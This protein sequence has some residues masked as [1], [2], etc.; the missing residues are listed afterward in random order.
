MASLGAETDGLPAVD[1]SQPAS[2]FPYIYRPYLPRQVPHPDLANSDSAPLPIQNGKLQLSVSR[3]IA[4]V[5]D[6]N[7]TIAAFRQYLSIAQTE[8]LRSRSGASPRGVDAA[9]IPSEVFAGAQGGS[10]LAGGNG[11]GGGGGASN[12]GGITGAATQVVIRPA[13][14]FDPT[15]GLNFS[16]DHTNNPLNTLV[17]AGVPSVSTGTNAFSIN[18]SQAFPTGTSF[19][20][21]YGMQRQGSTQLHLLYV[22]AFTPGFN[23]T[24]NQQLLNGFGSV[25]KVLIKVAENEQQIERE[26]F[27]R[28]VITSLTTAQNAYWD[29]V[30]AQAAVRAAEQ[31]VKAAEDLQANNQRQVEIG[32]MAT[33]DLVTAQ[34][35][36]ANSRRDLIVAQ[37][38][39]TNSELQLKAQFSKNLDDGFASAIIETTDSFPDPDNAPLPSLQEAIE[40]A[41]KNRPDVA[42]AE[43]N[44]KSQKDVVPFIQNALKPTLNVY[45]LVS[46]V[47]LYNF[48]GTSFTEAIRF[49]YPQVAFGVQ[50]SFPFRNRQAQADEVRSQIELHQAQATLTHTK[51]QIEVDVQ[52]ALIALT[53]SKAQVAAARETVR[54]EQQKLSDEQTKLASGLSTSYNVV[55]IQRDLLTA[56]L[57]EVQ[58]SAAYAKARVNLDQAMGVTLERNHITLDDAI[59]ARLRS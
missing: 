6:N 9:Q 34:S 41:N 26:S 52:N 48:F 15:L 57:A 18:Y 46:T 31:A 35:Q 17:V 32:T 19:T 22:P 39:L 25:N 49:K 45:G 11:A 53:Q 28:Q 30:A 42:V 3:L 40:T 16:H 55:L 50:L 56:E 29:L 51:S 47:G 24:I 33:L 38:S 54:L 58:A 2:P 14:L 7:L 5:V 20:I 23:F 8:L 37:N 21:N 27:R 59:K 4:A 1:Y 44:I 10:I 36:T 12:A 43:G 13:G